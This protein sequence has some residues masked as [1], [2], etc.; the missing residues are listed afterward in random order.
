[1][2]ILVSISTEQ[3]FGDQIKKIDPS[4]ELV[5]IHPD[6]KDEPSWNQFQDCDVFFLTYDYL[7]AISFKWNTKQIYFYTIVS[8]YFYRLL[9]LESSS[10][11]LVD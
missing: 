7:C 6:N 3:Y 10:I 1:M 9:N 11:I 4:I 8:K 2:K 5:A